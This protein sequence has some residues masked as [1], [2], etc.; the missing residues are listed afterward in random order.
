[1]EH[2][3]RLIDW[4][5]TDQTTPPALRID[6]GYAVM[7]W[8]DIRHREEMDYVDWRMVIGVVMMA[9]TLPFLMMG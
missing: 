9:L 3:G 4:L 5:M 1:M 6:A 2:C 8:Q 7:S